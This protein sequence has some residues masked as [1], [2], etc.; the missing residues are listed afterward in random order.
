MKNKRYEKNIR[1]QGAVPPCSDDRLRWIEVPCGICSECRKKK[2]TEWQIRLM[3][4]AKIRTGQFVTLTISEEWGK[5]L[6]EKAGTEDSEKVAKLAVKWFRERW[7]K[8]YK[9]SP[10]HFLITELGHNGTE[11]LHLHGIIF[12]DEQKFGEL[13]QV[14][15]FNKKLGRKSEILQKIWKYGFTNVGYTAVN[16]R[17]IGYVTKYITKYDEKHEGYYGTIL[18]SPGM[19]ENYLNRTMKKHEFKGAETNTKYRMPDGHQIELPL[20]YKRKAWNQ[21]QREKLRK[22]KF[23]DDVVWVGGVK[24]DWGEDRAIMAR[25]KGLNELE[26]HLGLIKQKRTKYQWKEGKKIEDANAPGTPRVKS[27]ERNEAFDAERYNEE[28]D[29]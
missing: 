21:F 5:Y 26:E 11:R 17:M 24:Y 10:R 8:E 15:N 25:K 1:N 6:A 9:T 20:Y 14:S 3:E 28:M 7:R 23:K 13:K 16:E 19:G 12:E 22:Y 4:E 29:Q 18:T 27:L 2:A